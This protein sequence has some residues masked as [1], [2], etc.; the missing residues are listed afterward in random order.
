M[1]TTS[2]WSK[3]AR[4]SL[5]TFA[6]TSPRLS[7]RTPRTT[8][9]KHSTGPSSVASGV[10]LSRSRTADG[11]DRGLRNDRRPPDRGAR[12]TRRLDRLG[13]LPALRLRRLLR[14]PA[15]HSRARALDRR[16]TDGRLGGPPPL[17]PRHTDPRDRMGDRHRRGEGARLH[18]AARKSAGHRP[19]RRGPTRS[20]R[21]VLRT[22]R[23]LRLRQHDPLAAEDRR[24]AHRR[25]R[26]RRALLPDSG[27]ASRRESA[28]DRRVHG[29]K[30]RTHSLHADVVPVQRAAAAC[31]RCRAC[32]G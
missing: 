31:D 7:T 23:P 5:P 9:S 22:D 27:R 29:S 2:T 30:G 21:H 12:G 10:S 13:V 15:R 16:T 11:T 24:R 4:R 26:T 20:R 18:A 14:G 8:T 28:D 19:H 6:T 1:A 25:R 32:A 3:Q 17:S